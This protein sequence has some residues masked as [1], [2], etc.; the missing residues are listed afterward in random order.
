M[1][2]KAFSLIWNAK[3]ISVISAIMN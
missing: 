2:R 3:E 1:T